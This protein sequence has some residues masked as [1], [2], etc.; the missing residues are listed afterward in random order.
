M[1]REM[2]LPNKHYIKRFKDMFP[3]IEMVGFTSEF[4]GK[5]LNGKKFELVKR[6]GAHSTFADGLLDVYEPFHFL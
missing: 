4:L 3:G 2:D 1:I 5:Y 6:S